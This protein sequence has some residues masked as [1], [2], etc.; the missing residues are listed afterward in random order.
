MGKT[1]SFLAIDQEVVR[2]VV[3]GDRIKTTSVGAI[4]ALQDE[5]IRA[6]MQTGDNP[7][8]AQAV[9]RIIIE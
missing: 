1:I 3:I 7:E 5:G 9:A 4:K 6:V 8:T 2:Y